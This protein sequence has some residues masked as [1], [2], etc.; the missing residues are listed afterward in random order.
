MNSPEIII[1]EAN[2]HSVHGYVNYV[3]SSTDF[4]ISRTKDCRPQNLCCSRISRLEFSQDERPFAR[5]ASGRWELN[6]FPAIT[7]PIVLDLVAL[8]G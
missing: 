2:S 8:F 1:Y 7:D 6:E 4:E 3:I 5:Y